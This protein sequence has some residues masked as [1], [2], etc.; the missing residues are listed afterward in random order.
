MPFPSI[1]AAGCR[2]ACRRPGDPRVFTGRGIKFRVRS[3]LQVAGGIFGHQKGPGSID[4]ASA[5]S[6]ARRLLWTGVI[7]IDD[8]H[9]GAA[10]RRPAALLQRGIGAFVI[11]VVPAGVDLQADRVGRIVGLGASRWCGQ[12]RGSGQNDQSRNAHWNLPRKI[13]ALPHQPAA[14]A[15]G[16][17]FIAMTR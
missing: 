4:P 2:P 5:V 13:D 6:S 9:G 17:A 8:A 7:W 1:I 15:P 16:S 12:R 10:R 14:R 11:A 3:R